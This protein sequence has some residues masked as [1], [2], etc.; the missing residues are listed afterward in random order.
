DLQQL[1]LNRVVH[2]V[3][4]DAGLNLLVFERT[5]ARVPHSNRSG[6]NDDIEGNLAEIRSFNSPRFSLAGEFLSLDR[7]AIQYPDFSTALFETE[8]CGTGRAPGPEHQNLRVLDGE[9]LLEGTNHPGGIGVETV[10][11]AILS[12]D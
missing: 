9:A 6:I 2:H 5:I 7:S 8:D 10:E 1:R 12:A 4:D 3:E 11:L